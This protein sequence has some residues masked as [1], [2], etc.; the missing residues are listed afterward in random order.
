MKSTLKYII[1]L[2]LFVA[3]LA[4][5]S[6]AK[7]DDDVQIITGSPGDTITL[8]GKGKALGESRIDISTTVW[9]TAQ[10]P[11]QQWTYDLSMQGVKVLGG[12][13]SFSISASPVDSMTIWGS[14]K[15]I[16][17]SRN[18]PV[19]GSTASFSVTRSR[20]KSWRRARTLSS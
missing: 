14:Y 7:G 3:L 5:P 11:G 2:L 18:A 15:G 16:R 10:R 20:A 17:I 12:K 9:V 13:N 4:P 6:F 1:I 8:N 19:S